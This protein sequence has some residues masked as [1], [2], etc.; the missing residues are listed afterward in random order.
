MFTVHEAVA[1]FFPAGADYDHKE[2]DR[3]I[4]WLESCGYA[5]VPKSEGAAE[6]PAPRPKCGGLTPEAATSIRGA[7][8]LRLVK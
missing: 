3:L 6:P 8:F 2:A 4:T 5:V 1:R 7:P